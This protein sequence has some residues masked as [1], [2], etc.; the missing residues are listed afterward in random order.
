MN[1]RHRRF[2][3]IAIG[4]SVAVASFAPAALAQDAD[5]VRRPGAPVK[6]TGVGTKAALNSPNCDPSTGTIKFDRGTSLPCVA[7]LAAGA[8]NGGATAPGVTAD[9]IKVVVYGKPLDQYTAG[10]LAFKP[11]DLATEGD[12]TIPEMYQDMA[13][14]FE[15]AYEMW[16]RT[17]E[18]E[19]VYSTGTD[20]AAQRADAVDVAAKKP[21]AVLGG[22]Q[23][24]AREVAARKI[25]VISGGTNL[26]IESQ[27][28]YR[29][30]SATDLNVPM[31]ALAELVTKVLK[32]KPAQW[33]GDGGLQDD[34]RVF[35]VVYSS[36]SSAV[37]IELFE[38]LLADAGIRPPVTI[39][40]AMPADEAEVS[41]QAQQQAPT[42]ISK[43]KDAGVTTVIP[44]ITSY[45]VTAALTTAATEQ[46]FAPEWLASGVAYDDIDLVGRMMDQE[47]W[48]HAFG[49]A[50]NVPSSA[51]ATTNADGTTV[52]STASLMTW[53]WGP[54]QGTYNIGPLGQLGALYRGIHMAG[55]DLTAATLRRGTFAIPAAGGALEE[56]V[57]SQVTA[58]GRQLELPFPQ[59]ATGGDFTLVFWDPDV[60]GTSNVV[61]SEG[62]GMWRRLDGAKRYLPGTLPKA[63]PPFFEN[64]GTVTEFTTI[65]ASDQQDERYPCDGCP[66]N[67]APTPSQ[68]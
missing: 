68:Q 53:Y 59:Y 45:Q 15:H 61:A 6:A 50:A 21:F 36:G 25:L 34:D 49:V 3:A 67:S 14:V 43:L 13:A 66:S 28:P 18:F 19:F 44:L 29:Q 40:F 38:R 54:D 4:C 63:M 39:E 65:P 10:D 51:K 52:D 32:G 37:E 23:V 46:D 5:G 27:Q 31:V 1:E 62:R 47:Q 7:P 57:L 8:D 17:V 55:P 64:E 30:S 48:S 20:E 60:E 16:G 35:G 12:G 24:F 41:S 22:G 9:S 26:D 56:Q 42:W 11:I 2:V 33:A 58:F